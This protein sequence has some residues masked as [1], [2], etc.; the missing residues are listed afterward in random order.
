M[1]NRVKKIL[2]E[3]GFKRVELT[4]DTLRKMGFETVHR[5]NKIWNNYAEMTQTEMVGLKNWLNLN[6]IDELLIP[7][8]E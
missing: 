5:F 6:S 3:R 7:D 8:E 2:N 1:K 4:D